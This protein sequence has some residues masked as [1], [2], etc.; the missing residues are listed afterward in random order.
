MRKS[1]RE[2]VKRNDGK[3]FLCGG[4]SICIILDTVEG[5]SRETL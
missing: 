1:L 4:H 3:S 2:K 5:L